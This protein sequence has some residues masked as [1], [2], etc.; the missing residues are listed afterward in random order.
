MLESH[1]FCSRR[2]GFAEYLRRCRNTICGRHPIAVLL[3][4]A[5]QVEGFPALRFV[6]YA[7]S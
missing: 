6:R 3:N 2:L 5:R 1:T 7:Q 4:A